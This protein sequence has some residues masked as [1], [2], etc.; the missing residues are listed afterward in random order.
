MEETRCGSER[1]TPESSTEPAGPIEADG[2]PPAPQRARPR[3]AD[4]EVTLGRFLIFLA[5][6]LVALAGA[7][8]LFDVDLGVFPP[9]LVTSN[10]PEASAEPAPEP[11]EAEPTPEKAH[12]AP[13]DGAAP[14]DSPGRR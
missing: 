9:R 4:I 10:P 11:E 1:E 7:L 12:P 13:E 5:F 8:R 2:C 6:P 3:Q 14:P